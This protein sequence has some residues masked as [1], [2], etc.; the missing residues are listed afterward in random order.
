[1]KFQLSGPVKRPASGLSYASPPEKKPNIQD[2]KEYTEAHRQRKQIVAEEFDDDAEY[3]DDNFITESRTLAKTE[4]EIDDKHTKIIHDVLKKYPHLVKNKQNI[5]LKITKA[6]TSTTSTVR[7]APAATVV[8]NKPTVTPPATTAPTKRIDSKKMHALIALGAENMEGP[9]LCLRCG[10]N[11]RPISIP[12]Y[13]GFRRH[14]IGT[15]KEKID[16]RICEHCGFKVNKRPDLHYHCLMKH[17]IVPP[18]N[19]VFPKCEECQYIAPDVAAL[20]KH[21]E[22]HHKTKNLHHCIYC[23]KT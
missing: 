3:V 17:N 18:Q 11:G 14:L 15:H 6:G 8:V 10:V 16:P 20:L 5:K 13:K 21:R 12:S 2:V 23:N 4:P 22:T 19:V 1:M 7:Q 9:W